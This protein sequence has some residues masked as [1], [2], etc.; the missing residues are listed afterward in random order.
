MTVQVTTLDNGMRVIS[1]HRASLQTVSVGVWVDVGSRHE[2]EQENGVSHFLEHMVFKGT[3]RRSAR[4]IAEEIENVGGHIN[5]Y[6]SRDH[7]TFYA[8][9]LKD[10]WPLALDV[11]ADILQHSQFDGSEMEREKDVILQEIGQAHDTPDDVV[12]DHLQQVSYPD[13]PLGRTI[14]GT[15]DTVRAL[16]PDHLRNYM[17]RHYQTGNIIVVAA[18]NIDHAQLVKAVEGA[19]S[20]FDQ[21]TG[22][23]YQTGKYQGGSIHDRRELE[24]NHV[25]LGFP[26]LAF[27]HED[28]YAL[29]VYS[30]VM[31]G[32]MSSRLFQEVRENRGLAYSVYSFAASHKDTGLFGIYAGTAP[33]LSDQMMKVI[34]GEMQAVAAGP[35]V[36][37]VERAKAQMKAGLMMLLESTSN[38]IEQLG[39]QMLLFDRIIP[40]EET[41][42][43]VAA[44]DC[45]AVARVGERILNSGMISITSVGE[46]DGMSEEAQTWFGKSV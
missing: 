28:Y 35:D 24:Q 23:N 30:T 2:S 6:T 1:E 10:D 36:A 41:L 25:A 34:A 46:G 40:T 45:A 14:L 20:H 37:E 12:F 8:R 16:S 11:L 31:G 3:E 44:V 19:F 43:K 7:T 22:G 38:R 33:E 29:Q 13:H 27:D 42:D 18:G 17:Q 15:A 39:R 5:A 4:D 21:G 26:G 32:G 9:V